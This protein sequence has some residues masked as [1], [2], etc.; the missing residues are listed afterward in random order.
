[1]PSLSI[2]ID[3]DHG[4]GR[5]GPGKIGLLEAIASAGSIS[6]GARQMK[7]SYKRAWDLVE[8]VNRILGAPVLSTKSGGKSGGGAELTPAG[9]ELIRRFRAIEDSATAAATEHLEAIA[10][11]IASPS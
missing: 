8:E 1:M 4:A 11:S 5:I 2:R 3:L 7:M 9:A 10:R 6:A